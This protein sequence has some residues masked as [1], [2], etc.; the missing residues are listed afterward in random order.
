MALQALQG[1]AGYVCIQVRGHSLPVL[2]WSEGGGGWS[3][4]SSLSTGLPNI[5]CAKVFENFL[6][7]CMPCLIPLI[8]PNSSTGN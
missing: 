7:H 5:F 8:I 6:H 1:Y 4:P 2:L 3:W